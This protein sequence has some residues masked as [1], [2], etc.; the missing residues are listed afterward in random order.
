MGNVTRIY[1]HPATTC[2][3]AFLP[4]CHGG[5]LWAPE[6][7]GRYADDCETGRFYARALVRHLELEQFPG[8]LGFIVAAIGGR[9]HTGVEIGF[10]TELASELARGLPA[11]LKP[12]PEVEPLAA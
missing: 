4:F 6:V 11:A 8:L 9:P 5:E 1:D 12:S 10:F 2:D 7:T 3:A